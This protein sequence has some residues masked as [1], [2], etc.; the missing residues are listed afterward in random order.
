MM[1]MKQTQHELELIDY[2]TG[3]VLVAR[4]R[5]AQTFWSRFCG[6]QLQPRLA[7]DQGLL[8]TRCSS[9]HT[10]WM[11]FTIDILFLDA[12]G[13]VLGIRSQVRPWRFVLGFR[14]TKQVLEV[15]SRQE[16]DRWRIGQRLEVRAREAVHTDQEIPGHT[17]HEDTK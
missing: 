12:S 15:A 5:V 11:R 8:I 10:H 3:E 17:N 14:G 16:E 7:P 13:R 9:V 2:E 6:L 1:G 4:L